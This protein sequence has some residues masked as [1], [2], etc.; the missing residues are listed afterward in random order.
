[1]LH[2]YKPTEKTRVT[3]IPDRGKYDAETVHAILDEGFV[4][5]VGFVA[6]GQPFVIPT[7]YARVG[8]EILFHG[9][10]ASRMLDAVSEGIAVCLT[11]T[12]VD[13]I[14]LARSAFH[15]SMNYRSVVV[16][17]TAMPVT[18]EV[19]KMSAMHAF[20][21]RIV[22]GRWKDV[23]IP[24][25]QELRATSVLRLPLSEVSAKVRIGPPK[26]EDADYALPVWAGVIP[27]LQVHGAPIPDPRLP[28]N[29][30]VPRYV[31]SYSRKPAP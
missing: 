11:V 7:L 3:R 18:G 15:H 19:E 12:L 6:E 2:T 25:K 13:G 29:V 5:H 20:T 21:E 24:T 23:R 30:A 14:V 1:M 31:V 27:L 22:A 9:S 28:A 4:C 8:E 26:D 16:L 10:A 17:G